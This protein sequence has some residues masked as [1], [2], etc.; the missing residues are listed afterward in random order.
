MQT[1]QTD[2][3][4]GTKTSVSYDKDISPDPD[5][6]ELPPPFKPDLECSQLSRV[7]YDEIPISCPQSEPHKGSKPS[8]MYED[9]LELSVSKRQSPVKLELQSDK[10]DSPSSAKPLPVYE[11][12]ADLAITR[13][14]RKALRASDNRK[15][16]PRD[17][18][19][20]SI[21]VSEIDC[22]NEYSKPPLPPRCP[23]G[24]HIGTL[25]KPKGEAEDFAP[26]GS[27]ESN[28]EIKTLP[29]YQEIS[30]TVVTADHSALGNH[31]STSICITPRSMQVAMTHPEPSLNTPEQLQA[32]LALPPPYEQ[33]FPHQTDDETAALAG[34]PVD[35]ST[36][37]S[38]ETL[39]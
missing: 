1:Q 30:N 20:L 33:M 17:S 26:S 35:I 25:A 6:P 16:R 14:T 22:S 18:K 8:P 11:D 28:C 21:P 27:L 15:D 29:I 10:H 3:L 19:C 38:G 34:G 12:I 37:P 5:A 39:V 13:N 31:N 9:I 4:E 23:K 32:D 7:D 2:C 24:H 36:T